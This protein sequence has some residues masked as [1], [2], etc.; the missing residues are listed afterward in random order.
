VNN[1]TVKR[2][3]LCLLALVASSVTFGAWQAVSGAGA[4]SLSAITSASV[5]VQSGYDVDEQFCGPLGEIHYVATKHDVKISLDLTA[6]KARRQYE[7]IWRNN[8]V[9]GYT[10][11]AFSTTNTGV[12]QRGTLKLFRP[13]EVRGVGVRIYYLV[14]FNPAGVQ[15]F[16]PC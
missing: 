4:S 14:G 5:P 1:G 8:N 9:R 12:V 13:G 7:I 15:N 11:G 16:K 3:S 6:A 10:I 2:I